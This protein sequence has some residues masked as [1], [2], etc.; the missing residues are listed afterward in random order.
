MSSWWR[1]WARAL[2][3]KARHDDDRFSDRVALVRTVLVVVALGT[4]VL[5][6]ANIILGWL[7]T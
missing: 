1:V 7:A 2:G 4:N 3:E 5:I 6:A